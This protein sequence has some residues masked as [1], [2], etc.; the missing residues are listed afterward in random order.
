LL[1][2]R[3][4][5]HGEPPLTEVLTSRF[6]SFV[7]HAWNGDVGR[8]R[9]FMSFDRRWL[10]S[11]GSEDSHGRTL[12]A[13]GECARFDPSP[14]RR[15]W[16]AGL[17]RD[18][19]PAVEEFSAPR[20]WAF[21][22]LGLDAYLAVAP[23]DWRADRLRRKLADW[24]LTLLERCETPDWTWFEDGLAYDNARL[25]EALILTGAAIDSAVHLEAGLRAL[26]WLARVQTTPTGQ[27]RPVGTESFGD[28]RQA[29]RAFDQQPVEAAAAI[30]AYLAAAAVDGDHGW[31]AEATRAFAWF[32]G[33]NDLAVMLADPKTGGCRDG[34]HP[35]RPNENQ[36][37]ESVLSYLLGLADVRQ[38]ARMAAAGAK[39]PPPLA[40]S[41]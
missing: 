32:L 24:L 17:F 23:A 13:L 10:E 39:F 1:A 14:P 31:P 35:D 3:L 8:F 30:G 33:A 34:L 37:A 16:A 6:A 2:S 27:F 26:R 11:V 40:I 25:P 28:R 38:L 12:W 21:T 41:A 18:A 20:S 9:N 29:P 15:R 4:A 22:L 19:L 5:R 36:G 7:Q